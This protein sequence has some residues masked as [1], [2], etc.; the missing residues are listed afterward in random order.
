MSLNRF[1]I[2]ISDTAHVK[3]LTTVTYSDN[4][5]IYWFSVFIKTTIP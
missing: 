2:T 1:P 5:G 3:S 4:K